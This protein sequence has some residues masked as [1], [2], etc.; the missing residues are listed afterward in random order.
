MHQGG[1]IVNKLRSLRW[2]LQKRPSEKFRPHLYMYLNELRV[3]TVA[4]AASPFQRRLE[5]AKKNVQALLA[6]CSVD[7]VAWAIENA[8]SIS[9]EWKQYLDETMAEE[10]RLLEE[11]EQAIVDRVSQQGGG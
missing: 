7:M 3:L 2:F 6:L 5:A 8:Q 10:T 1:E 4:Y 11:I 9:G